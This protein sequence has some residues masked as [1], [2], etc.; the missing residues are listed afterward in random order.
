[1][2]VT[3]APLGLE[4][5]PDTVLIRILELLQLQR[6]IYHMCLVNRRINAVADPVLYKSI[7]FA[8]PKHH[9]AFSA[10]LI[11]RP[12]RG[13]LIQNVRLEY[14]SEELSD[15]LHMMDS[16]APIDN[17]SHALAAMSNLESLVLSVPETLCKGIGVLLND[18]FALAC[19]KSCELLKNII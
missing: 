16:S 11:A 4:G 5:L 10:S 2:S 17:F 8:Q 6:D 12:R 18:P 15:V 1:M 13:S 7:S 9:V 14:P 19:L 3:V